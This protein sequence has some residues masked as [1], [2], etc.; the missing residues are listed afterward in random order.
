MRFTGVEFFRGVVETKNVS[1]RNVGSSMSLSGREEM[2]LLAEN[3]VDP[4]IWAFKRT[5]DNAIIMRLCD[6]F[7][8]T[9]DLWEAAQI[10]EYSINPGM[11][12]GQVV[13][14][15]CKYNDFVIF[16]TGKTLR[17][18]KL[19]TETIKFWTAT[20]NVTLQEWALQHTATNNRIIS[21]ELSEDI[22]AVSSR[23]IGT[24]YQRWKTKQKIEI[25]RANNTLKTWAYAK[26]L[27]NKS[28]L[29]WPVIDREHF[30]ELPA[31]DSWD[32]NSQIARSLRETDIKMSVRVVYQGYRELDLLDTVDVQIEQE[33]ILQYM[34]VSSIE[35]RYDSSNMFTTEV[36]LMPFS[37]I[38]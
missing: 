28:D 12:K 27:R 38:Q 13:D 35:Y 11:T 4:A 17:K 7:G 22:T 5:T 16:K 32:A 15:V 31:K 19:P 10:K 29:V 37:V 36:E 24:G 21:V 23:L 34:Y 8:W 9:Y 20:A 2:L 1:L 30:V 33:K 25:S 18:K 26:K 14:D 6:S 3:D